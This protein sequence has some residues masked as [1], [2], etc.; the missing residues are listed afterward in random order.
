[1]I[2]ER[3]LLLPGDGS[4][5]GRLHGESMLDRSHVRQSTRLR[6]GLNPSGLTRLGGEGQQDGQN[7]AQHHQ[8]RQP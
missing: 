5:L 1:L 6:I 8:N 3:H 2:V 4:L 7:R